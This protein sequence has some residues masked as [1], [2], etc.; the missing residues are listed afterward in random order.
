MGKGEI[1]RYGN[2]RHGRK[3]GKDGSEKEWEVSGWNGMV[4]DVRVGIICQEFLEQAI[5]KDGN[6]L[7]GRMGTGCQ[8]EW[9][10]AVRK[11]GIRLSGRWEQAVR[12]NRN[13]LSGRM[14][15]GCQE[16]G[17]RLSGRM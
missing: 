13:R 4:Q 5:R 9:E 3:G 7:S 6:R 11:V 14:G 1:R 10:Q 12:K 8:E 2:Q 17:N 15:T 16:G